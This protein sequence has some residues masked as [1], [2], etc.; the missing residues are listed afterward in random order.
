[1]IN[2]PPH[3]EHRGGRR[4]L[5]AADKKANHGISDMEGRDEGRK[6]GRKAAP[7]LQTQT[8]KEIAWQL[9]RCHVEAVV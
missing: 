9:Q 7:S 8:L 3:S 5:L 1:M 2:G 4:P 6:E